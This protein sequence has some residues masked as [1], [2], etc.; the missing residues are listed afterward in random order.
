[1]SVNNRICLKLESAKLETETT[2]GNII[3]EI[4][5]KINPAKY[6]MIHP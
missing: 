1:M 2:I 5:V 6:N 4:K 3:Y